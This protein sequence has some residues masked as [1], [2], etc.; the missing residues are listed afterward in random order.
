[1][2]SSIMVPE[3]VRRLFQVLTGEDMTDADEGALFAVA[4]ALE[5]G[6]VEVEAIDGFL[7]ELVGKVR[8][9]FSG[10][11][12]D[13]FAGGLEGF[14]GLLSAGG[15]V[16]RELAVFVRDLARQVRYLKLVTIYGLE[17]L[18][19]EMAWAVAMAGATGGA[20]MAWLAA[21]FALMR[22]LLSRW[23]GQLFMRLAMAA[24][25]GVGFNVLPDVQAQLQ[26]LGENSGDKWD[27]KLTAQAAG[28]GAFSALVSLPMSALGGLVG[29]ALT[30]VLVRGLG[31]EVDEAILEA[32]A[33]RAVAEHAELYPVS[34][35]A[36]FADAVS[37]SLDDY[38][39]MSVLA[40]WAARFADELG[41]AFE[42][43]L[44]ELFGDVLYQAAMGGEVTWNLFSVTAG[45]SESVFS[46]MGT[47]AGLVLRGKLHPDGPS[48][49]L[50]GT[51][52]REGT[53][54]D[55]GGFD[56]EKTPLLGTGSGS[57]TGNTPGSPDKD[58]TSDS[59]DASK[60][61]DVDSVFPVGPV[62]SAAVPSGKNL[63]VSAVVDGDVKDVRDGTDV[64][65][66]VGGGGK[67]GAGGSVT[68]G[69]AT[70]GVP[71]MPRSGQ[72]RPVTPPPEYSY[73]TPGSGS[74]Q[75]VTSPPPYSPV[76][77][78][79]DQAVPGVHGVAGKSGV[80]VPGMDGV[81]S[82]DVS[83]VESSGVD[84]PGV[85][86][87]R[88]LDVPAPRTQDSA[89]ERSSA[90]I[91]HGSG[92]SSDAALP[93][94]V[95]PGSGAV[96]DPDGGAVLP[97][98]ESSP[99][100]WTG[101]GG[102]SGVDSV[103]GRGVWH[104]EDA[105][106]GLPDS[107]V[108]PV[109]G[110]QAVPSLQQDPVAQLAGLPA[111]AV[112]VPVPAD[113]VGG[114][115]VEFVRDAVTG[116][117]GGPVVLVAQGVP[118]VGVVVSPGQ[119]AALAREVGRKVV[120]FTPGQGGRG[121]RW[122]VFAPDGSRPRPVGGPAGPVPA[123]GRQSMAG[124]AEVSTAVPVSGQKTVAG[125]ETPAA[126]T[127]GQA[128]SVVGGAQPGATTRS[129]TD[130]MR[131]TGGIPVPET[132]QEKR[133]RRDG[134]RRRLSWP[135]GRRADDIASVGRD[136][137]DVVDLPD[138]G[139][140]VIR[141]PVPRAEVDG[142]V[143]LPPSGSG[144]RRRDGGS[145]LPNEVTGPKRKPRDEP[146]TGEAG[147][148]AGGTRGE[149]GESSRGV[150]RRK[151]EASTAAGAVSGSPGDG[152]S[153]VLTPT[154]QAAQQDPSAERK[155]KQRE[156]NA[157]HY[158]A[159]TVAVARVA[160]LE[161]LKTQ[162]TLTSDEEKELA[163]LRPKAQQLQKQKKDNAERYRAKTAAA[164]RVAELEASKKQ[165][166]LTSDE[167]KEL[168]ELRP[169]PQQWQK[170]KE[171]VAD[172]YRAGKAAVAS[173]AVLEASKK[174]GPLTDEQEKELKKL[175]PKAQQWQKLWQKEKERLADRYRVGQA[176][177]ASVAVLEASKKQ[178]PLTDEQEKELAELRPKAQQWQ[179]KKERFADWYRAG[180]A[181]AASVAVLEASKKQGPLTDEQEKE[182]AE[183][184]PKA[185]QWQKQKER[186]ADRYRAGKAAAASV[187]VLEASKKEGP[188]TDEQEKELK[189]LQPKAQ[190]WQKQ[191]QKKKE[192]D[193]NYRR[194]GQAAVDRVAVL[195][196]SKEQG[197]LTDEQEKELAELRS[198]VAGRGRKK[199]DREVTETGVGGAPVV[200][201]G[202]GPEGVSGWTGADQDGR[203]AWSAEVDLDAWLARAVADV[204]GVQ[205]PPG[206]AD[207]GVMLGG[208]AYEEFVA[209]ELLGFLGQDAGDESAG[210]DGAG[211]VAGDDDFAAFLDEYGGDSVGWFGGEGTDGLF[212]GEPFP[213]DAVGQDAV[214]SGVWGVSDPVAGGES[215]GSGYRFVTGVNQANYRCGDE[216]FRVNCLEAVVA[217]HN[218]LKFGRQFVAGPAGDRDPARLEVAFGAT[219]RRVAGVAGA[220]QYVRSGPV[221]VAVPVIYQRADGSAHVIAAVH[222][223]DR[224]EQGRVVLLDPQKGEE[225]EDADVLAATGMW[226]IPVPVPVPV[227][228]AEVEGEVVLPVPGAEVD[229]EVVL[230]PSGSGLR[231]R[232][233]GSGLPAV[234]TGP[235]RRARVGPVTGEAGASAGRTRGEA[236]ESSRGVKRR[237]VEASTAA[238]G[239]VSGSP[240][241]G[242]S[243]VLTPTDQAAQQDPSAERKRKKKEENAKQYRAK[244]AAVARVAEL[245][246]L[247]KQG[248]L[249][250][251]E[252]KELAELRPKAQKWQKKK[253]QRAKQDRAKT[254]AAARVAELEASKKQGPLTSDEEKELKKLR[255][256]AQLK[257]KQKESKAKYRR[258]GQAAADRVVVLEALKKQGPL[259]D[260]QEKEL[261]ELQPKAQQWQKQKERDADWYRVGKA[262]AARVAVLEASKKQGPLTDEQE[263]ELAALR[264]KAQRWQKKKERF[265]D[266]YRAGKA[267]AARVAVLE[268]SKKQGP[269]TDEQEAELAAL[270]PKAQQWQKEKERFVDW[271]WAGKAAAAR[272]AVLE[273]L[274]KQGR[275]TDEQEKELAA[276][277]SKVAG[278]GRKKKDREVTETGVGGA[279]VVGR[280]AGPE[281]VSEQAGTEHDRD[282]WSADVDLDAWLA[283]AVADVEGAQVPPGAADAGVMLSEGA[284]E[285]F[286]ETE[287]LAFLG[288]DAGDESAGADSAGSVA[289]D[290]DFAAFLDEY[291]GDSVG[292]FGRE[293]TDG[294]FFGEPFPEDAE[295][296]DAVGSGVWG[297]SDPVAGGESMGSGYRF[298]TGVNQAN[299][300]CGDERFRV[301][302][303]EAVVAFHNSLKFGRQF[304][305]GPAGDRDPVRLEVAFGATAR[306]VAGVA[307]AEQY[308]RSGPVGVAVP[309][310]YQRADGSAHVIAAVHAEDRDE[311]GRVV[312]LDPQKGEEAEDADVLAATG[313]WVIPVPVPGAEVD[314]EVVLPPS[315]S[316]LRRQD[317]G[318]G[319]PAVVTGPKRRGG[320][321]GPVAG[322]KGTKR[323]RGEAGESSRGV[324][325]R[326]VEASTAA[327]GAVSGSPGDGGSGVLT[328]TDQAA[329]QDP[330][331][332]RKRK[333]KE[334]D[335]KQYRAKTAAVAR[336]AELEGLKTKRPLTS[337]EEKE[338][339]KLQPKVAQLKQKKK[340]RKERNA[341]RYR[342]GKAAADRVA[343][344][345]GLKTKRPL[346]S[347]EEK[348]LKKLQ[349]KVAQLKQ[350]KK[351]YNAKYQR[352][353][354]AAADRVAVLE[355]SK[356]Q[357]PLTDEQEKE[358]AALRPKAQQWQKQ[359]ERVA[360][361]RRVVKA[362]AARVAVLEASKKQGPLTDEQEKELAELRPKAQQW[363]KKKERFVDWYW[364]VKAA[365]ARV[366]VLEESKKQ[367]PLT[368]EQ[369][370]ELAELRP[371]AQQWQKQRQKK[372]ER[373]ADRY[374][375]GKAAAAR[376]AVLEASK[377]QGPLTDEQEKEL[378][379]L[380]PKAQQWQKE[381]ERFVDWYQA[382]KA[383][384][385]RVAVLEASKKQGPLTDEQGVEL[386]ALRSKVAGRG[387]KK[388]REVTE[389]GVGGAPVV[390]RGVGPEGVSGW[391]GAEQDGRDAW[392]AEVDLDAWLARAVA[393]VDGVQVPPGAADA[394][395]MLGGDAYEEFVA[396]ELLAFL[397]QDAGDDAAGADSARSVAGDDDFAAFLDEYGGDSVG[398]FGGEGTD[399]LFFGEPFPEDAVGPDAVWPDAVGPDAVGSGVWGVSDPVAGGESMGSGYRFVTG[400]NQANYRC[401]DERFRVNCLEAVVAFHNSLKFGRQFVAGPAGDRD[402]VR[403][404]VAFGAKAR[405]VA[406][407]AG[408]EQ[409]VRSG[410]VGVAVPVIYQRA[411]GSAHVIAAVHAEDRDEQGRVVLLDPQKGEEAEDADVLAATGM[412]VI[413]V[414]VPGA[415]VDGEVVLPP[416]GSGLR[417]QDGGSGL[418]AVVTGPKRRGG[419]A[420]PVAGAKGTK[421]TRG[422]AGESSRG[423]KRRKVEASTAAAGTVSG[424]PGDGGS[425]VLTPTDQ[426]AQQDPSA[427]RKR[428]KKE[429][430]AERYRAKTAA[431]ARVAELEGLKK[432][433]PLTSDEE[434]ELAELRPKAQKWQKKKERDA[435]RYRAKTDAAARVA[436][437][438][439]SKKQGP[440]TSDEEKELKKL[441]PMA[442][443]W[444]K[445]KESKA[446]YRRAGQAAADRV[447]VLEGLKK[448]GP[449]TSDEEKEL[450][451]L[452]PKA[453]QWQK[454]KERDADWYRA[455][456]DAAARVAELEA[457]KK[458]GPLTSDE[459]KELKKLQPKA[460]QWQKQKEYNAKYQRV[461]KAAAARV[462]ELEASKKQ[463]PL[464]SDE[465]KELKKL[466]PKAQQWQKQKEYN[467]KYR[468]AGKAAADRVAVLEAS[469]KQ[470][471]LTD[472]QEA[473]L[474][475]L[476]P[477]AQRWQK[478]KERFVDWYRAGKAAAGVAVL[479]ASKK[480]GPL[481]DEQEAEL[482]ALRSKVAGRGRKKKDREVTET[483]VGGAPVVGRGVGPEG[484]SEQAGAERDGRD[485]WSAEVDLDA[486]LARAVADVD[487][488]QVPPGAADAGVMLGGDAYEEFVA[489]ELLGFLGQ[490]AGDDAAGADSARSVAG[491]DD[492]AAFLD[493]YGGDSVGWFGSEGTDGL[494]FGEPFPEDA[495]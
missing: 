388:D 35:M 468:R 342:V 279:P 226:V 451:E 374:R 22:M 349:P 265:V 18:L 48:P 289:G 267:A 239:T 59:S 32:A 230:P 370:K 123:G 173:V 302:C 164:D 478:K 493:E 364:V 227:P 49:Y 393:D 126:Q 74:D 221:G 325:R 43:A 408:A 266:W 341:D 486:W 376:V 11:A 54:T 380:R 198:K 175:Q 479:E 323:T 181:A 97:G 224:D 407:V 36:R 368:D 180:K 29:N 72:H 399:G 69:D 204:E 257:Q 355:E 55:G 211:S 362:A 53:T 19:V 12:A 190:Q 347:D 465:E 250:S 276:L 50:E 64:K 81:S 13:R 419:A 409:Y 85:L 353:V 243:E 203:D 61:S 452:Q 225:A 331:A 490:D 262:A 9:E 182:L 308:V 137:R 220:E 51:S 487:G 459:E 210:A 494:F 288:Q 354:K 129:G 212:F 456:T 143:V 110:S 310:I 79:G 358:L 254:A 470:G 41:D 45:L 260:E 455:K 241:D 177:V 229:G 492:F 152:G 78:G 332:E 28:M 273:A 125:E 264:P 76:A 120:A 90:G 333:K 192:R 426:A 14:D 394:G 232:D 52:R 313:M 448:Q 5:S 246:G 20:S 338:L 480:Q 222:R 293:G 147:A 366:A 197:P 411:D 103:A 82:V 33:R 83:G 294:L 187:A 89:G 450:A 405:R 284:Y 255:P 245:E 16:L 165:G 185:Q 318:S 442:Q 219:A 476:R 153:E 155:R 336:V 292:W 471:P 106:A 116:S 132:I 286:V 330:S 134:T 359:K 195:E 320:A 166:P 200:G 37:K 327:A 3:E 66:G 438:E 244:T 317:G 119:G 171:R 372:K 186:N 105:G 156:Y 151:V 236:G 401:G 184:R 278:R 235:K 142:E 298:V 316:G 467:A 188:L 305:A 140:W 30:K 138:T 209:T 26:M 240:G 73:E 146:V 421:R 437:L 114:G 413:P 242:G 365:A 121:P 238:A 163:E 99:G 314:G 462:A 94:T 183:L 91:P 344:L 432:Q 328:P 474:A 340:E 412:W 404:E 270:R 410:P 231:R 357:G 390:G 489:T 25:G 322:A 378:A 345:E 361:W 174:E 39:E 482:A 379:A 484:V 154:D 445:Q 92:V 430:N 15:G 251:D 141:V 297:V 309:V 10:K 386:A 112:R 271:Y 144:L 100:G 477:K 398:W 98:R 275:L 488:V 148:S 201:R 178:G 389:T 303:L 453:Q 86:G 261:A 367:G 406:G 107:A 253:E 422:E 214:G 179:K 491:D 193:A 256:M 63:V 283:R 215:M 71:A 483:G 291:G 461:V 47:V 130:T 274:K 281:G 339:K 304:V 272:V 223:E 46:G 31:D 34:A 237:K 4:D 65:E 329:Q 444:Q 234:V 424:S 440:L 414:P 371:K 115:L 387:R 60:V 259:T 158:R 306:R 170:Q 196:A 2:F 423:V 111:D 296:S 96:A 436:E 139:M 160:E 381:K 420:G 57:Q 469:K 495:E 473:E 446:K 458:Q 207:A 415:E 356:K 233:G 416:S 433:G 324:K 8:T 269:L 418:P 127:S 384:A 343:E 300:R 84:G 346:T 277:R 457:S 109:D 117:T 136:G 307:G 319:L 485:A 351:E 24:A 77:G 168:A 108:L 263:A 40:M 1:M 199:K 348:E 75:S 93:E 285:E 385:A 334:Y 439:A 68:G 176:A 44:G 58:N 205:V 312:L 87:G 17:L 202:V 321:A 38:A 67:G 27:G 101:Q 417:R 249:T 124:L 449:L 150:K 23:W 428:K 431:V 133:P 161:G 373:V 80:D 400:V 135:G 315:G 206:A 391:A 118:G 228:G 326:K 382:R 159:K 213:E 363:Q 56:E 460:Q 7:R 167:E 350:K 268:A 443:Q 122:T 375:A 102:S 287:L 295:W 149:A 258:A 62:D 454:Q 335:A 157:K 280:G 441:Q 128:A 88:S 403:L 311:Q 104:R 402:P 42:N 218:S 290:D 463:G 208:D 337:D 216:R 252:E 429:Y 425:E 435:E 434:K 301:N 95:R 360:D 131:D 248:P 191:W 377:K 169:K 475:E 427:E 481:T 6:A 383:A 369:E 299:Y 466:Q 282:A 194:A 395:V 145:G 397:G 21:R 447:V 472:E 247:K 396:T 70:G 217:F 464:T 162:R 392:S 352:V 189:K 172:W 113:V